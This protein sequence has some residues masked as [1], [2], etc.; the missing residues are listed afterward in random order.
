MHSVVFNYAPQAFLNVWGKNE[1]RNVGY[2]LRQ[3]CDIILPRPRIE[4]FKKSPLY[5]LAD[6]WNN[7]NDNK[8][9]HNRFT[10]KYAMK[11]FIFGD[12]AAGRRDLP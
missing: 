6:L 9:Q 7:L 8:Y 12:W 1:N 3:N 4:L 11:N 10:F 2:E 5:H